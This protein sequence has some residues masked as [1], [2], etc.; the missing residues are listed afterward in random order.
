MRMIAVTSHISI[1]GLYLYFKNK[2]D[3]YV[4][5]MKF[6]MDDYA[7]TLSKSLDEV[8]DPVEQIRTYIAISL[9][10]AKKHKELLISRGS[11]LGLKLGTDIK[12]KFFQRQQRLVEEI[13]QS[14][15]TSGVF[16]SCN[17][18]ESAQ[19]IRSA[20]RGFIVSIIFK[21]DALFSPEECGNLIVHGLI[22]REGA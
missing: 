9:N 17:V 1:G 19:V 11:E 18:K 12:T 14:G 10:Y 20:I 5:L 16:R 7:D 3:L 13:I 6:R 15:I 22:K 21:E 2:E 4:T 8:Q